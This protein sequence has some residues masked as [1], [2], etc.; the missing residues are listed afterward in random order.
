MLQISAIVNTSF[1][2]V[3]ITFYYDLLQWIPLFTII[4]Y[5]ESMEAWSSVIYYDLL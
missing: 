1:T 5:G 3:N 2:M 4:Y